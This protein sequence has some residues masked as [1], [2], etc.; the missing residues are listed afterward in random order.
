MV[1]W[2]THFIYEGPCLFAQECKHEASLLII[3]GPYPSRFPFFHKSVR[4]HYQ[5]VD[6]KI[7]RENVQIPVKFRC[8]L[9]E[10]SAPT[11]ILPFSIP[12]YH[13][14]GPNFLYTYG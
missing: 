9:V 5:L 1:P 14:F 7:K 3:L 2:L 12:Q 4:G 13:L 6:H 11:F 10:I 8:D